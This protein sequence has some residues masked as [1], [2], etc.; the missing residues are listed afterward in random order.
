VN[1]VSNEQSRYPAAALPIRIKALSPRELDAALPTFIELLRESVDA[2]AALGFVPPLS[3]DEARDYWQS[4]RP[5]LYA[6]SRVLLAACLHDRIVGS[7]QLSLPPWSNGRHRAMLEK[8]FVS[9]AL[10]GRGIGSLLLTALQDAARLRGRSLLLINARRGEPAE[11][12]Y[13]K[14][15]YVE[16]GVIP[17]YTIDADGKR[18][19]NV[20]L[21]REIPLS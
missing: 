9:A 16:Y 21:Y 2:G 15:G 7:G 12:L 5:Q 6:G 8:L 14:M 17:G 3:F 19:D 1:A 4:V 10:R 20:C 13:K 18:H 11:A